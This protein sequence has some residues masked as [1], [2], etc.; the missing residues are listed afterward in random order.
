MKKSLQTIQKFALAIALVLAT[1]SLFAQINTFEV[2]WERTISN[3]STRPTW[4]STGDEADNSHKG[5]ER[6]IAYSPIDKCV[7]VSS[8]AKG[9]PAIYIVD[10]LTG[11]D[12][13][14]MITNG[15]Y[16]ESKKEYTVYP[17][18]YVE[19]SEDGYVLAGNMI[20]NTEE[21]IEEQIKDAS[22]TVIGTR[23]KFRGWRVWKWYSVNSEP[24]KFIEHNNGGYR[25]GDKFTV[26]G[27]LEDDAIIYAVPGARALVLRWI[28]T[29]GLLNPTPQTIEL[30]QVLY[31][32]AANL[33]IATLSADPAESFNITGSG[34]KP[35]WFTADGTI[36]SPM[37]LTANIPSGFGAHDGKVFELN[38]RKYM[39]TYYYK[40][41][42]SSSPTG[43]GM[44]IDI[45]NGGE[46]VT[47]ADVY[48]I[49][50]S[51]GTPLASS[52]NAGSVEPAV[53]NEVVHLFVCTPDVGIACFRA[54]QLVS[55]IR[56]VVGEG[57]EFTNYPNP[58]D[59]ETTIRYELPSTYTGAVNIKIF[60]TKGQ[61]VKEFN[62]NEYSG[63]KDILMQ[64]EN[65]ATGMYYC[66]MTAG[67]YSAM[68][69]I[70][71]IR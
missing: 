32:Q 68:R 54:P 60:D 7:L 21:S 13:G 36:N 38:G 16:D 37:I 33:S 22:G 4:F 69:K 67:E 27:N 61:L 52:Y 25:L 59:K 49:T 51:I 6:G 44:I 15:L 56:A 31:D 5:T 46:N 19:V 45:T 47:D 26:V 63:K 24:V 14:Q 8:R 62:E 57:V 3:N 12:N 42:S 34:I 23:L 17:M 40:S 28:V 58:A 9:I 20:L 66:K 2:V 43:Q 18:N 65:F 35:T 11:A 48:G 50:P 71:V 64:T 29:D 41:S 30:K 55:G 53:I 70:A 10:P 39:S 1:S